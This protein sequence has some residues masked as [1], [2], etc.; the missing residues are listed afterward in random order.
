MAKALLALQNRTDAPESWTRTDRRRQARDAERARAAARDRER[1]GPPLNAAEL[2]RPAALHR[3]PERPL[4]GGRAQVH[5]LNG[6]MSMP[7]AS[8]GHEARVQGGRCGVP[9]RRRGGR[10]GMVPARRGTR[11]GGEMGFNRRRVRLNGPER[12]RIAPWLVDVAADP[13]GQP[14]HPGGDRAGSR[15]RGHRWKQRRPDPNRRLGSGKID[16]PGARRGGWRSC[17]RAGFGCCRR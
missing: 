11:P 4:A 6:W 16:L 2:E 7:L 5:L 10:R 9:G 3:G 12:R 15:R 8:W 17:G 14:R 13:G 1:A